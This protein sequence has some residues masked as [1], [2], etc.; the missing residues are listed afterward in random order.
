M[1]PLPVGLV[2][3]RD[4]SARLLIKQGL[5][6][7]GR[8]RLHQ[9]VVHHEHQGVVENQHRWNCVRIRATTCHSAFH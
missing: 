6:S 5:Q 3:E 7:L 2:Q 4:L 9:A 1:A 8:T